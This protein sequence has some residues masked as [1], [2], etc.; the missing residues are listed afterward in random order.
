MAN[1][2]YQ[3]EIGQWALEWI[4]HNYRRIQHLSL[5]AD[6]LEAFNADDWQTVTDLPREQIEM[7]SDLLKYHHRRLRNNLSSHVAADVAMAGKQQEYAYEMLPPPH[8][9][10]FHPAQQKD[11]QQPSPSLSHASLNSQPQQHGGSFPNFASNIP[12]SYGRHGPQGQ[13]GPPM[14]PSPRAQ[15]AQPYRQPGTSSSFLPPKPSLGADLVSIKVILVPVMQD[16]KAP[17]NIY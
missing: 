6:I 4:D 13:Q 14:M 1:I 9:H 11:Y 16:P 10:Q 15:M 12:G 2:S 5:D 7:L 17:Q 3:G 8:P